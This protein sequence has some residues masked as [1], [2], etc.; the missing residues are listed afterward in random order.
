MRPAGGVVQD[1]AS[2]ERQATYPAHKG[3]IKCLASAAGLLASGGA[4]DLIHLYDVPVRLS[5]WGLSWR[6]MGVT[7]D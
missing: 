6:A 7:A 4:D 3:T 2:L 1:G 5:A